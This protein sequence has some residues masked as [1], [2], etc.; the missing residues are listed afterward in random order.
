MRSIRMR[1]GTAVN[2]REPAVTHTVGSAELY[3]ARALVEH[4][5]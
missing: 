4:E 2:G 5:L 1:L 3:R